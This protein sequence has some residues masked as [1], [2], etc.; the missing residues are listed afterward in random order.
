MAATRLA[1]GGA[2]VVS[3]ASQTG[4]AAI[5]RS[6]ETPNAAWISGREG[7]RMPQAT[8]LRLRFSRMLT[9]PFTGDLIPRERAAV[10]LDPRRDRM[11]VATSGGNVYSLDGNGRTRFHYVADSELDATPVLDAANDV[12]FIAAMDGTL[13]AVNATTGEQKYKVDVGHPL[14]EE[15][16]LFG[17]TLFVIG[18]DDVVAAVATEDGGVLWTYRR[19]P[20]EEISVSGHAGIAIIGDRLIVGFDDGM[21]AALRANDGAVF[22]ELDTSLDV[23]TA[24]AGPL[25]LRDVDTT[26]AI[27]DGVAYVASFAGGLYGVDIRNGTVLYRDAEFTGVT[28]IQIVDTDLLIT[29]SDRGL[30]RIDPATHE[31]RWTRPNDRGTPGRA[32]IVAGIAVYGESR[33]SLL[34]V[35]LDDGVE[36]TRFESGNGFVAEPRHADGLVVAMSNG[37]RVFGLDV[38]SSR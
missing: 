34:A 6:F 32:C 8:D 29:S 18:D 22:W 25:R 38:V 2:L 7:V 19:P 15:P 14:A 33:G 11:F 10:A 27:L 30:S 3:L 13:H 23:G 4:C 37:G 28:S 20:A 35:R 16:V 24:A 31:A 36:V 5:E 9:R 1:L 17:D 12:L 26:P 21:L